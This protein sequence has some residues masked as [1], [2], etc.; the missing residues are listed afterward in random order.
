MA[1][2]AR[3]STADKNQTV[4]NSMLPMKGLYPAQVEVPDPV[5]DEPVEVAQTEEPPPAETPAIVTTTY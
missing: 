1:I 3:V 4:E 5:A 2:Y